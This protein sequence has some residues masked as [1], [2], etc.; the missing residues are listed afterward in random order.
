MAMPRKPTR[1]ITT[2]G[3]PLRGQHAQEAELVE[4]EPVGVEAGEDEEGDDERDDDRD[5]DGEGRPGVRVAGW[6]LWLWK[7]RDR[8]WLGAWSEVE[9]ML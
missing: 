2:A 1:N 8:S 6:R 3:D 9:P 4:P 7:S 5:G